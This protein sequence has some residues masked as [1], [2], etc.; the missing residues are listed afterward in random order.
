MTDAEIHNAI[1][2]RFSA[3]V[4]T[5]QGLWTIYDNQDKAAPQDGT[6]WCRLTIL[7]GDSERRTIGTREYRDRGVAIA[8]LFDPKAEGD[9]YLL[10]LGGAVKTAFNDV[11]ASGVRYGAVTVRPVGR[12]KS[13]YQINVEIPF[14][15]DSQ[16]A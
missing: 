7:R 5:P 13:D 15:A 10:D 6:R 14:Q 16:E 4:A 12:R 3:E 8:Q 2:T 1:R 9:G 11:T